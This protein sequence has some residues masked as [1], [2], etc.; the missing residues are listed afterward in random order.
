MMLLR[1]QE[2]SPQ[3]ITL[4]TL[5]LSGLSLIV[6]NI[7]FSLDYYR[8]VFLQG[9]IGLFGV[10]FVYKSFLLQNSFLLYNFQFFFLQLIYYLSSAHLLRRDLYYIQSLLVFRSLL[11]VIRPKFILLLSL[12]QFLLLLKREGS[13]SLK[14]GSSAMDILSSVSEAV[15]LAEADKSDKDQLSW[16]YIF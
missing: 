3:E 4:V 10:V 5:N 16:L 8:N 2:C 15:W 11:S 1:L 12:Q 14:F 13:I 9:N 6:S 7:L